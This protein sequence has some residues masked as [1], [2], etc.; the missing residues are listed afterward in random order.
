M[1]R[2]RR[3]REECLRFSTV[4]TL[5]LAGFRAELHSCSTTSAG[6]LFSHGECR[7]GSYDIPSRNRLFFL[8]MQSTAETSCPEREP[9]LC[10]SFVAPTRSRQQFTPKMKLTLNLPQY[11]GCANTNT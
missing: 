4:G 9:Q 1:W 2:D 11:T 5:Q 8:R 7:H 3:S 10:G 6:K